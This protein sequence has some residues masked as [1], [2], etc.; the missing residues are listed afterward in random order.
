MF[1]LVITP[2][3][4]RAIGISFRVHVLAAL[5]MKLDLVWL[6]NSGGLYETVLVTLMTVHLKTRTAFSLVSKLQ[7][8]TI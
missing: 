6:D 3:P 1:G 5:L 2:S 8:T 7:N 4:A